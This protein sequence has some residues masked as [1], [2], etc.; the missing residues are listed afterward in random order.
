[1]AKLGR[2]QVHGCNSQV[3]ITYH[4]CLCIAALKASLSGSRRPRPTR[5]CM[6]GA[7]ITLDAGCSNFVTCPCSKPFPPNLHEVDYLEAERH[8][9][10][11]ILFG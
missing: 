9:G 4:S 2:F 10:G 8:L 6:Q 3:P 1:M 11:R 5:P 7:K